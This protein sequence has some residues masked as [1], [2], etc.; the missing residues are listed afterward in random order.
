MVFDL[1]ENYESDK[2][3]LLSQLQL[4]ELSLVDTKI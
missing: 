1:L 3:V 2:T 4:H